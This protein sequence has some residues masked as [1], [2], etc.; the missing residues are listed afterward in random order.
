MTS[1][2]RAPEKFYLKAFSFGV[3][4]AVTLALAGPAGAVMGN[5]SPA[6]A[7][8]AIKS[9][10][11]TIDILCSVGTGCSYPSGGTP[12]YYA[13]F[14]A[15]QVIRAGGLEEDFHAAQQGIGSVVSF[16][17]P[18]SST[19]TPIDFAC[20]SGKRTGRLKKGDTPDVRECV[21]SYNFSSTT[22]AP[23]P[24]SCSSTV[25]VVADTPKLHLCKDKIAQFN[26]PPAHV[27]YILSVDEKNL[28][29]PMT[30]ITCSSD[31]VAQCVPDTPQK[32]ANVSG[33]VTFGGYDGTTVGG[34]KYCFSF[35]KC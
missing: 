32:L 24:V 35:T 18:S 23:N 22:P 20:W 2:S 34:T 25:K 33:F 10:K 19:P 28:S 26:A 17:F 27:D 31:V 11:G 9:S 14:A 5:G 30:V 1:D 12:V 29:G 8:K 7:G 15:S 4:F 6:A 13:A 16:N 3:V 21:R